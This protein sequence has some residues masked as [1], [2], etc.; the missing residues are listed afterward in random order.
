M[1]LDV[2]GLRLR[3]KALLKW[4]GL[5]DTARLLRRLVMVLIN[6]EFRRQVS[7]QR[8]RERAT[9][10]K[11]RELNQRYSVILRHSLA[12]PVHENKRALLVSTGFL[13][14]VELELVLVK[15]LE[16]AGFAPAVLIMYEQRF[17]PEYFNLVGVKEVVSWKEFCDPPDLAD[18]EAVIERFLSVEELL[19]FEYRDAR[20][21]KLAVASAIRQLRVGD[22]DLRSP[23]ERQT[24]IKC[25]A[26][27]MSSAI[28]AQ[29]IVRQLHPEL[30]LFKDPAYTPEGE[31][32]DNCLS[33]GI[34][35]IRYEAAHKSNSLFLKRYTLNNREELLMSLSPKSW[36][37]VRSMEWNDAHRKQLERELYDTY[38]SGDWYSDNLT[39]FNTRIIR[40]DE[41]RKR[42]ALNPAKK[43]ALIFPH[44]LWDASL[45]GGTDL[46]HSYEEWFIECV[47][48]ACTNDQVNWGIKIHPANVGKSRFERYQGEPAELL[49]LRKHIGDL[50]PHI[51]MIPADSDIST[52]SLFGLIDYCLTVRGTIGVEAA[53]L[54]IPV[55][56]AGTGGYDRRGFTI[57]SDSREEYIDRLTRIQEYPRLSPAQ[58]ELAERFAYCHFLLRPLPL[59]TVSFERNED[60]GVENRFTK[61]QININNPDDWYSAPDLRAFAQW[62]A[63]S[64][65]TDFM[66]PLPQKQIITPL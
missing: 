44:I 4:L 39:Q 42:L 17:Y 16:L 47:R 63:D 3:L 52:F 32:V 26:L 27:A 11:L 51:F 1:N 34:D 48:V 6:P 15:A 36:Q 21:G 53:R 7:E 25:L 13:P 8:R 65:N 64:N 29:R 59:K 37:I 60:Y 66:M 43:T 10:Q 35:A 57:D 58:R 46:F 2:N 5:L 50:P 55:L 22:L 9:K 40:V 31:L 49:A 18:A 61:T 28:T 24:L 45:S 14:E 12:G 54:G 20:V 30:L 62:V 23:R 19:T 33:N 38:A 41:L 56:T